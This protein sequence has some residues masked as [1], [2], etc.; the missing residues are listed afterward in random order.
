MFRT[1][2]IGLLPIIA[3]CI[4]FA[5]VA[6]AGTIVPGIYELFDHPDAQLTGSQGP[7]GLR[8]DSEDPPP[9]Q[10]PTFSVEIPA[11]VVTLTWPGFGTA[12]IEGVLHN[13]T[14]GQEWEVEYDLS[15]VSSVADGI[16]A[17]SASGTLTALAPAGVGSE[18]LGTVIPLTG[19]A[20]GAGNAFVF[21]ADGHRLPPAESM[22]PVGRGWLDED[23]TNDWLV[24][25]LLVEELIIPEP[26]SAV[27]VTI[28]CVAGLARRR[29]N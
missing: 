3:L 29:A 1:I 9:G 10:G 16:V 7:Y 28:A 19:E 11:G 23:G 8:L 17:T 14:T 18:P 24:V 2:K 21:R 27:L 20:N 12:K 25:G 6:S 5:G 13:N 4:S 26:S 15:G 22:T